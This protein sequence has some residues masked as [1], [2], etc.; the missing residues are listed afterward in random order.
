M[1]TTKLKRGEGLLLNDK[2]LIIVNDAK[3]AASIKVSDDSHTLEISK[4]KVRVAM[5]KAPR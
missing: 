2:V 3:R 1:W 5:P 4:R